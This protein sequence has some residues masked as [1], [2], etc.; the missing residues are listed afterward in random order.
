MSRSKQRRLAAR[1]GAAY[2]LPRFER[3]LRACGVRLLPWQ[4]YVARR[5]LLGKP[6]PEV[7]VA[8]PRVMLDAARTLEGVMKR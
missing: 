7:I 2:A 3:V 8:R 6:R 4:E 5:W 1:F